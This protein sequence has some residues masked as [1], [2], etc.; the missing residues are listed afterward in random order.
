MGASFNTNIKGIALQGEVSY[1]TNQ[2]LQVD[3]VELLFA[4]LSSINPTYGLNNQIGNYVG[5]LNTYIP[6]YRRQ[7]V[8]TGQMTA[9]KVGRGILGAA[10]STLIGEIGFVNADLPAK[11][12]LRFDGPG[13]FVGG[14]LAYMNGSGSNASGVQPLSESSNAFADKFSWGYQLVGRLDYNNVFA[15]V[16][17]SPLAVFAQDVG[18]N[19]PL[20]LGNFVHGRKT[21]TLGADFTFQ[22]AWAFEL[23]YV[24]FSGGGRFNLL[25]DRDY[26]SATMKYSF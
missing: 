10:Q 9:T 3:D 19:T 14:E 5:Q 4:A 11:S 17:I 1:R 2:P 23:R 22:N 12:A 6:G 18:G 7:K 20:P 13:T 21:V 25:S 16:N 24:N 15:G 26:V 8:W